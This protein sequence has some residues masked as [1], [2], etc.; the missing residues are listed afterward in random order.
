M[1]RI[2]RDDSEH[3]VGTV[4]IMGTGESKQWVAQSPCAWCGIA[5]E[6]PRRG[7]RQRKYCTDGHRQRAYEAR[8]AKRRFGEDVAAG[9]IVEP[10][11]RVVQEVRQ[12][13]APTTIE[14]W[15]RMLGAL[16]DQ[17][18]T[19]MIPVYAQPRIRY[20]IGRV[21]AAMDRSKNRR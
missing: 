8:V 4:V 10:V 1:S 6:H 11:E 21:Q 12:P 17:I 16:V 7:G 15:E 9:R 2:V 14:A 13:P 5:I 20:R 18:E 19:G 3:S